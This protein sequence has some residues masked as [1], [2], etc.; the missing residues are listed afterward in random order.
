[1]VGGVGFSRRDADERA[2]LYRGAGGEW[3]ELSGAGWNFQQAVFANMAAGV[4]GFL[5]TI[6]F[7]KNVPDSYR[8]QV[9]SFF[10]RMR[11]L[12][13]LKWKSAIRMTAVN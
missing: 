9:A 8:R 10:E 3:A 11:R 12:S 7:G 13:I 5:L 1:M 6:P 4:T 2:D